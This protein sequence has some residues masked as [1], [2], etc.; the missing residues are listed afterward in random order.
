MPLEHSGS[1]ASPDEC[2]STAALSTRPESYATV[3]GNPM[4]SS[5]ARLSACPGAP[6]AP[7]QP[8]GPMGGGG[9]V[10]VGGAR[11]AAAAGAAA[12]AAQPASMFGAD[13]AT[14][15]I[16]ESMESAHGSASA[17]AAGGSALLSSVPAGMSADVTVRSACHATAAAAAVVDNGGNC[18]ASGAVAAPT[19]T[20]SYFPPVRVVA[21]EAFIQD[22]ALVGML[23]HEYN[24]IC[25]ER[26]VVSP[27]DLIVD[28]STSVCV[29]GSAEL[30]QA[31]QRA[32]PRGLC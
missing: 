1:V 4:G 19:G 29:L 32:A 13:C 2:H 5:T 15:T 22:L 31:R 21:G 9:V 16:A 14:P 11:S 8:L 27:V 26:E 25:A 28:G 23:K 18:S 12:T 20:V 7:W 10:T 24:V 17:A 3:A 6:A 30:T